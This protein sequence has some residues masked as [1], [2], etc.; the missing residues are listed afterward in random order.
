MARGLGRRDLPGGDISWGGCFIQTMA[1][2]ALGERTVIG[3]PVGD[4]I[5]DL[6]GTVV[7]RERAIGFAVRFDPLTDDQIAVLK[8]LL[9]DS[10][11][12]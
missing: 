10:P 7:Y 4:R 9:G 2:P 12:C 3:I 11:F 8:D 1:E 5:V 6:E